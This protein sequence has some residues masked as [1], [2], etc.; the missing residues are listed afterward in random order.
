MNEKNER[1]K[2]AKPSDAV[3]ILGFDQVPQSGDIFAEVSNE[4]DLKKIANERQR[5]KREI[6]LQ[7]VQKTSLDTISAQIKEGDINN[8]NI[9]IK[10]DSDG[11][12]EALIQSIEKINND[13]VGVDIVHK[14]VGN[15]SESDVQSA[16]C[17]DAACASNPARPRYCSKK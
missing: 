10:A 3:Q 13:E 16:K 6:D 5:I 9:I 15:V 1:I 8:L 17:A 14:G 12:I 4:S 2:E 11:S 7:M